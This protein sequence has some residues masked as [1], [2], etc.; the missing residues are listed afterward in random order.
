VK[1]I[2]WWH[3]SWWG[4]I[5]HWPFPIFFLPA[6]I[7]LLVKRK[8]VV[9]YTFNVVFCSFNDLPSLLAQAPA[10][11]VADLDINDYSRN[12]FGVPFSEATASQKA[13]GCTGM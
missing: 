1:V 13:G 8:L 4:V 9:A 11:R 7:C 12:M 3:I 2:C 10:D 5:E 6:P